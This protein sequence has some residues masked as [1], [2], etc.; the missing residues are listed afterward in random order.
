MSGVCDWERRRDREWGEGEPTKRSSAQLIITISQHNS[1]ASKPN[2]VWS[3]IGPLT[4]DNLLINW[5]RWTTDE[6][7]KTKNNSTYKSSFTTTTAA[8]YTSCLWPDINPLLFIAPILRSSRE[9]RTRDP[10]WVSVVHLLAGGQAVRATLFWRR[11]Y[12]GWKTVYFINSFIRLSH[13]SSCKISWLYSD[14]CQGPDVQ[15]LVFVQKNLELSAH[16]RV[17]DPSLSMPPFKYVNHI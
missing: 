2:F 9:K 17:P 4:S 1:R 13:L 5:A 16:V 12:D 6:Q 7:N 15:R 8:C 10:F 14:L 3:V 11:Q